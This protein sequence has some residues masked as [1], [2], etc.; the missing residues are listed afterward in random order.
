MRVVDSALR[1]SAA[2]PLWAPCRPTRH[3]SHLALLPALG[4]RAP[5]AAD[6]RRC[7]RRPAWSA[8][9]A[10]P[11]ATA[12]WRSTAAPPRRG[13]CGAAA[14]VERRRGEAPSCAH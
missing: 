1:A 8:P 10:P 13:P 5:V 14:T 6:A 9:F 4:G 11:A 7:R 3:P 2:P 12:P